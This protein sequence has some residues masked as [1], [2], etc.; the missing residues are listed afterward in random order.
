MAFS[1]CE[2]PKKN[3]TSGI[4]FPWSVSKYVFAGQT[5]QFQHL[6]KQ[7]GQSFIAR[8]YRANQALS[9]SHIL[10]ILCMYKVPVEK[11]DHINNEN[12]WWERQA[13]WNIF[14]H[15]FRDYRCVQSEK[16]FTWLGHAYSA[17]GRSASRRV[18]VFCGFRSRD[19]N[20]QLS[21]GEWPMCH[22]WFP[23]AIWATK[24]ESCFNRNYKG[25]CSSLQSTT[26]LFFVAR[27]FLGTSPWV[28]I[29]PQPIKIK[30]YQ[31]IPTTQRSASIQWL[32]YI[33]CVLLNQGDRV[34]EKKPT[35]KKKK[36]NE[37]KRLSQK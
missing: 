30:R 24:K 26:D 15:K 31:C 23:E 25:S 16:H 22:F 12:D 9:A 8:Y 17:T 7:R 37:Q 36:N 29:L 5:V 18:V 1:K 28:W 6:F 35:A 20:A 14:K 19:W 2:V 3:Q 13:L 27:L 10:H 34:L 11:D 21:I 33:H 32:Q 4:S